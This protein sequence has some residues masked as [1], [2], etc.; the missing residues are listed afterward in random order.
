MENLVL[1]HVRSRHQKNVMAYRQAFLASGESMDGSSDLQDFTDFQAWY[2]QVQAS[3]QRETVKAGWVP[4]SQY[5]CLQRG[6]QEVLGMLQFRHELNNYLKEIGGHIGYS[7]HPDYRNQGIAQTMLKEALKIC[8]HQG[9]AKVL[10]TCHASNKA[11]QK[12]IEACGGV[13]DESSFD[14]NSGEE[15]Y[16]YWIQVN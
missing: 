15:V 3:S 7:V 13:R 14:P 10:V 2:D 8:Y 12:V 16:R 4:A 11:S 9:M 1:V 5:I 6:H